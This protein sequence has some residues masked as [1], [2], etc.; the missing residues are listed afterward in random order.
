MT[1]GGSINA[2]IVDANPV[3]INKKGF[4]IGNQAVYTN[5]LIIDA[6]GITVSNDNDTPLGNIVINKGC[7]VTFGYI[8]AAIASVAGATKA[9]ECKVEL[10]G[11]NINPNRSLD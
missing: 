3:C 6:A 10:G 4:Q 5:N 8:G 1:N 7:D 11:N 2:L 9:S